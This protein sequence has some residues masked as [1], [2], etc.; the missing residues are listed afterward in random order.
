MIK[1]STEVQKQDQLTL[2]FHDGKVVANV[3]NILPKN[4]GIVVTEKQQTFAEAMTALEE[5]V[6][7]L[8]QG[9]VPLENAIDLYKQGME[10]S[11]FCH[12]STATC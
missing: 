8:E 6:R 1:S 5:I 7:Q 3:T 2:T 9:D 4:E 12:S 11:K 10:L